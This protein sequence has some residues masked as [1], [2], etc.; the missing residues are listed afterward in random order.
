MGLIMQYFLLVALVV[1]LLIGSPIASIIAV[2]TLFSLDI[3]ITMGT[4]FASFW[5]T[6][7]LG[8]GVIKARAK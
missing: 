6:S 1:G 5:L 3:P 2:N 8:S 4:W 7:I